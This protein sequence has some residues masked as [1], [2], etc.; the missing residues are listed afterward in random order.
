MNEMYLARMP[1]M[2]I[3]PSKLQRN[4]YIRFHIEKGILF[5]SITN[6]SKSS[7]LGKPKVIK[8]KAAATPSMGISRSVSL[9]VTYR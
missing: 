6:M 9:S 7:Y 4:G 8:I 5:L 3:Y 1:S 2:G